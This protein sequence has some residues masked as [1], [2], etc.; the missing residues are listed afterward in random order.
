MLIIFKFLN[1]VC[2]NFR[3]NKR[4]GRKIKQLTINVSQRLK[5]GV[6]RPAESYYF[7]PSNNRNCIVKF[8]S[9]E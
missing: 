2:I 1:G 6:I 9:R 7:S 5:N 4:R 3:M 8:L